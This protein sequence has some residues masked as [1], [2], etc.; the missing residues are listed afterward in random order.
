MLHTCITDVTACAANWTF[1]SQTLGGTQA[2]AT[3][4]D[5]ASP[6]QDT[7]GHAQEGQSNNDEAYKKYFHLIILTYQIIN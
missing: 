1:G 6:Q 5:T 3:P 2:A 4:L 7:C